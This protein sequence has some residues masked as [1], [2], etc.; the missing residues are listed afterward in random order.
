MN[1]IEKSKLPLR[2]SFLVGLIILL[3]PNLFEWINDALI[4]QVGEW[5]GYK[6]LLTIPL[7]LLLIIIY[8]RFSHRL[9]LSHKTSEI[10]DQPNSTPITSVPQPDRIGGTWDQIVSYRDEHLENLASNEKSLLGEFLDSNERTKTLSLNDPVTNGLVVQD[11][12]NIANTISD[13]Q[14]NYI[15]SDWA[16]KK[17]KNNPQILK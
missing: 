15:I 12:L 11:I 14:A 6:I 5:F 4:R 2:L 13:S 3:L 10:A 9:D 17:L 8:Q 16:W 1:N 7:F